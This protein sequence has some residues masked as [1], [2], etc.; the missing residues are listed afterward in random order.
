METTYIEIVRLA[1]HDQHV[2]KLRG[3]SKVHIFVHESVDDQKSI[4]SET[5][6]NR[7]CLNISTAVFYLLIWKVFRIGKNTA[8]AVALFVLF[9]QT[10]I[11]LR[12]ARVIEH[13]VSD[14]RARNRT[15]ENV[16]AL[17]K[18]HE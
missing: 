4:I 9:G 18:R 13:P 3:V 2:D 16:G 12:V 17:S 11:A 8:Q 15:L 6:A 5:N 14:R 7:T 1:Q 10:H